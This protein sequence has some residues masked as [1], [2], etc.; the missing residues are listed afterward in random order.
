MSTTIDNFTKQL[1]DNLEAIED[2]AKL[3]KESV[4]SAKK[5]LKLSFNPSSTK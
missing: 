4:Q 3:L 2:R 1:H 5:I